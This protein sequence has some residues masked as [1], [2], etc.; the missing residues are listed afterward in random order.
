M[1][2][3]ELQENLHVYS[4]FSF[5]DGKKEPGICINKYN[6]NTA[7]IEYYFVNHHN[8]QAYKTALDRH[9]KEACK[10]LCTPIN[11]DDIVSI[12]AVSL[13]DYKIIM[14]LLNERNALLNY[15]K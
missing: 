14:Q 8:M 5:R 4:M 6:I 11:P 2:T 13:S 12:K 1:T 7:C 15:M 10:L 9:D 3:I